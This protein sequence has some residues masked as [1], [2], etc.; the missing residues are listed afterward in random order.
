MGAERVR[1]KVD[2]REFKSTVISC[3]YKVTVKH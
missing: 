1:S 3:T 2:R